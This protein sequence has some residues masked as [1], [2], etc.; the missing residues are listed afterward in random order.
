MAKAYTTLQILAKQPHVIDENMDYVSIA[1][2][3]T[4]GG[5]YCTTLPVALYYS[6]DFGYSD[7]WEFKYYN[8]YLSSNNK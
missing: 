7:T 6:N 1:A 5:I 2:D 3:K 8:D 4:K